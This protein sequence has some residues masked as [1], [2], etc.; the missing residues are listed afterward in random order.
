MVKKGNVKPLQPED[1]QSSASSGTSM[2]TPPKAA[3]KVPKA[4]LELQQ[5]FAKEGKKMT[6]EAIKELPAAVRKKVF[7]ALRYDIQTKQGVEEA[8]EYAK[9]DDDAKRDVL[10]QFLIDPMCGSR[11][12]HNTNA[13][14]KFEGE[15]KQDEWCTLAELEAPTRCNGKAE[16]LLYAEDAQCRDHIRPAY[17]KA[18]IKQYKYVRET[19]EKTD[20]NKEV[21]S[22]D[23]VA[24]MEADDYD[25][26]KLALVNLSPCVNNEGLK[27]PFSD[28]VAAASSR[29]TGAAVNNTVAIASAEDSFDSDDLPLA[30]ATK[31]RKVEAAEV[32]ELQTSVQEEKT[33]KGVLERTVQQEVSKM[34]CQIDE[35]AVIKTRLINK[36]SFIRANGPNP[37]DCSMVKFLSKETGIVEAKFEEFKGSFVSFKA[38]DVDENNYKE[39]AAKRDVMTAEFNILKESYR[40]FCTDILAD[41]LKMVK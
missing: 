15:K 23:A 25:K 5:Q 11:Q 24:D 14:E 30:A 35:V 28:A 9:K 27:V 37:E 19:Y 18:G 32:S 7:G 6:A 39:S 16:A 22:T 33:A 40:V 29:K 26:V 31:R 36:P 20:G 10:V 8:E 34:R 4:I 1:A 12:V 13:H 2:K 3:M 41:F 17:Q 21:V 38:Y